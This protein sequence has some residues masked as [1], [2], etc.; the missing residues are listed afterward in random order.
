MCIAIALTSRLERLTIVDDFVMNLIP[1]ILATRSKSG[2]VTFE[3]VTLCSGKF[4]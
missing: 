1:Y 4:G 2:I 3:L